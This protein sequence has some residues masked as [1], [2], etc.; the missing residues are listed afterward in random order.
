[1]SNTLKFYILI[2]VLDREITTAIFDSHKEAWD[3]MLK[4]LQQCNDWQDNWDSVYESTKD[5]NGY[6]PDGSHDEFNI[7]KNTAWANCHGDVAHNDWSIIEIDNTE[8]ALNFARKL[9]SDNAQNEGMDSDNPMDNN[10]YA[11]GVHDGIL[12]MILALC[13]NAPEGLD[14]TYYN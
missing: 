3:A 7:S 2:S 8:N 4:E 14:T 12:D 6:M 1:M 9:I 10:S 11:C 5:E 13:S